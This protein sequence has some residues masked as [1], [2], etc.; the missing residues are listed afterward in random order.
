MAF[1]SAVLT[2]SAPQVASLPS[3]FSACAVLSSTAAG[4]CFRSG[5]GKACALASSQA[6]SRMEGVLM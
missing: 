3:L 1:G 4:C 6:S 2:A 5:G